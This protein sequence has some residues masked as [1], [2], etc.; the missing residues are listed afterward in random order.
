MAK[1]EAERQRLYRERRDADADRREAYLKSERERW[2]RDTESGKKKKIANL[3]DGAKR[4]RRKMWRDAKKRQRKMKA[5]R[6]SNHPKHQRSPRTPTL[7]KY[8]FIES[9]INFTGKKSILY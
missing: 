6:N 3:D 9:A 1:T 2:K 8:N 5:L 7:M 4:Q